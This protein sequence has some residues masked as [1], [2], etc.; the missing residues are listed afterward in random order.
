ML[1]IKIKKNRVKIHNGS[2]NT[3]PNALIP[4]IATVGALFV[5]NCITFAAA[6][7]CWGCV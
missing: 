1:K 2:K 4:G 6:A 7:G 5:P 3:H